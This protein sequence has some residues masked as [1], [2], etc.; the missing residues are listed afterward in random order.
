MFIIVINKSLFYIFWG[1]HFNRLKVIQL[2]QIEEIEALSA[3]YDKDWQTE[4]ESNRVY[5]IKIKDNKNYVSLY[6][7]LPNDYPSSSPP[8]YELSAPHLNNSKKIRLQ[9]LLDEAYL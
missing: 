2:F 3:I 6:F 9:N 1:N 7:K 8:S 5:S 4:D